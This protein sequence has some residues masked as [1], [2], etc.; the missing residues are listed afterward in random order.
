[1]SCN[2]YIRVHGAVYA[3]LLGSVANSVNASTH[4]RAVCLRSLTERV[5]GA[6][7]AHRITYDV[8]PSMHPAPLLLL[9]ASHPPWPL[10]FLHSHQQQRPAIFALD[11]SGAL[12]QIRR[13]T[14]FLTPREERHRRSN[15]VGD[16]NRD[17]IN[18]L[19]P[20]VHSIADPCD[21]RFLTTGV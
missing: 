8:E 4:K 6:A 19:P 16:P 14:N 2:Q 15:L 7:D 3:L 5:R 21:T 18:S 11:N 17:A 10:L 13:S 9:C 12:H 20:T 1:M